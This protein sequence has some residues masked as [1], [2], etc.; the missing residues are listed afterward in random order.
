[1]K[2]IIKDILKALVPIVI[3]CIGWLLGQVSGFERRLTIIENK[4]PILITNEGVIIDSPQSAEKRIKIR[5]DIMQ[6]I[7][8]LQIRVKVIEELSKSSNIK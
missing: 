5:D 1:M 8:Q 4:I 3:I 2:M 6:E 7:H